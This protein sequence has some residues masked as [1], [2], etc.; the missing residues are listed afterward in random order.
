[1]GRQTQFHML[2]ED[3]KSFLDFVQQRDPVFVI[4]KY[5]SSLNLES[6]TKA[7]EHPNVYCL[8][9]QAVC[10]VLVP[11]KIRQTNGTLRY[12]IDTNLPVIEFDYRG[13]IATTWNE[14]PALTQGRV[15]ASFQQADNHFESWYNAVIRWLRKNFVRNPVP[16]GGFV[17]PAAYKWYKAGGVLLPTFL[18]P[19]TSSWLSWVEAQDQ[20]RAIFKNQ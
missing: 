19:V 18:P 1:M 16:I 5:S 8:W 9:N 7:S 13:P 20:N 17:G 12:H 4:E 10:P 2:E 11:E 3:C 15:W 14:R 6:L